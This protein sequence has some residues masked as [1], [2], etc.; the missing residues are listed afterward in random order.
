MLAEDGMRVLKFYLHIGPEERLVGSRHRL[1]DETSYWKIRESDHSERDLWPR[2]VGEHEGAFAGTSIEFAPWCVIAANRTGFRNPAVTET[3]SRALDETG[4]GL[5][6]AFVDIDDIRRRH[7]AEELQE[8]RQ[9]N[10]A[11]RSSKD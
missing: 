7:H 9:E 10:V 2:D 1:D 6:P 5:P 11:G 8:K 4:L 3:V